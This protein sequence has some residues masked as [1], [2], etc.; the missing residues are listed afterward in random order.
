MID[1]NKIVAVLDSIALTISIQRQG[2]RQ[3]AV[4][5]YLQQ[6][7]LE[8]LDQL[9]GWAPGQSLSY[10]EDRAVSAT[11][12]AVRMTAGDIGKGSR[13][14]RAAAPAAAAPGTGKV[15]VLRPREQRLEREREQGLERERA[16]AQPA[17]LPSSLLQ[18][19][20]QQGRPQGQQFLQQKQR[21][22]A[23]EARQLTPPD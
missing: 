13:K 16:E 23:G 3:E 6:D 18:Q 14:A 4:L 19:G 1:R 11:T 7:V 20:Q 15:I 8:L 10:T 12:P 5:N 21:L 2:R 9:R 22:L 17:I